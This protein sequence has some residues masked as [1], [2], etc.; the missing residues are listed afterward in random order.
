MSWVQ[1]PDRAASLWKFFHTIFSAGYTDNSS[2]TRFPG[3][4]GSGVLKPE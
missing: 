4:N 2:Y 3:K 1:F